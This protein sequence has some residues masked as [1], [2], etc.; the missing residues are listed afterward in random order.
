[1]G[2]IID[3]AASQDEA[4]NGPPTPKP[5]PVA[6]REPN[7]L[8]RPIATVTRLRD[9]GRFGSTVPSASWGGG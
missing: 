8:T 4:F 1:M 3:G 6:D 9:R 5:S 2:V 7:R